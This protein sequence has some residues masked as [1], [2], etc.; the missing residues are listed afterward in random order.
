MG[1]IKAP[2]FHLKTEKNTFIPKFTYDANSKKTVKTS[3]TY[4][5]SIIGCWHSSVV[6]SYYQLSPKLRDDSQKK[7]LE[8]KF[9]RGSPAPSDY[10]FILLW[11]SISV[12]LTITSPHCPPIF[13]ILMSPHYQIILPLK[14]TV[15]TLLPITTTSVRV[16]TTLR[17]FVHNTLGLSYENIRET[18]SLSPMLTHQSHFISRYIKKW[19]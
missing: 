17:L 5:D 3:A 6:K 15:L 8:M 1:K 19:L 11:P 10:L 13:I 14:S 2:T 4:P 12:I 9:G 18:Q 16:S 7:D